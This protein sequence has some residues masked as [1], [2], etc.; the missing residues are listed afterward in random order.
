MKPDER[1]RYI[2]VV[3]EQESRNA[4]DNA[5]EE[6]KQLLQRGLV[7][8]GPTIDRRRNARIAA[9][10]QILARRLSVEEEIL[11]VEGVQAPP[12]WPRTL[13]EEIRRLMNELGEW[14]RDW[15]EVDL[16]ALMPGRDPTPHIEQL[17]EDLRRD[18]EYY[19]GEIE[20]LKGKHALKVEASTRTDRATMAGVVININ[21]GTVGTLNAGTIIGDIQTNLT[22]LKTEG[23]DQLAHALKRLAEAIGSAEALGDRRRDALEQVAA[24]SAEAEKPVDRRRLGIVKAV[25]NALPTALGTSADL[26][27]I[28]DAA[29]QQIEMF[30]GLP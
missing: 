27:A 14:V 4:W 3:I 24:L 8:S 1:I 6:C 16:S 15:L 11:E 5:E 19:L 7:L 18:L 9:L 2:N 12:Q 25:V 29:W 17:K 26:L 20:V 28:W 30:F 10:R 21:Q 13:E 23:H 22:N